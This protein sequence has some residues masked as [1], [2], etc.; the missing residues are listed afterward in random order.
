MTGRRYIGIPELEKPLEDAK[1]TLAALRLEA[2]HG[3]FPTRRPP[4]IDSPATVRERLTSIVAMAGGLLD[5]IERIEDALSQSP[6]NA[7]AVKAH[8]VNITAREAEVPVEESVDR[9]HEQI[10]EAAK[11][12]NDIA[13]RL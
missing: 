8:A 4:M 2:A 9:L 5:H 1:N 3:Y 10:A 7:A 12:L 11:R 6:K 13:N